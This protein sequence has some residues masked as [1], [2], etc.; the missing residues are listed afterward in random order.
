M[1]VADASRGMHECGAGGSIATVTAKIIP[2]AAVP[3]SA[4]IAPDSSERRRMA[5]SLVGALLD[6][7]MV[8]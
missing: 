6:L 7:D 2:A 5:A 4:L 3:Y 1:T 8:N